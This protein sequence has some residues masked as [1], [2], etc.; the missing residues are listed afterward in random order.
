[1]CRLVTTLLALIVI[2]TSATFCGGPNSFAAAAVCPGDYSDRVA[3]AASEDGSWASTADR[4]RHYDET[5]LD[6]VL[7]AMEKALEFMR[8]EAQNLNLDAIIGTRIVE[9]QLDVLLERL[10]RATNDSELP[11]STATMQRIDVIRR[12]AGHVSDMATPY[13]REY[14]ADYF[15]RIGAIIG[16]HF[17]R[18]DYKSRDL[19]MA[20]ATERRI[21]GEAMHEFDSDNCLTELFGTTGRTDVKC[22]VSRACWELMT[23]PGYQHYSLT[24]QCFYFEIGQSYGCFGSTVLRRL[25]D[26]LNAEF[27]AAIYAESL[28]IAADA[29]PDDKHD[30]FMEQAA[31]CGM[32]GYRQFFRP[33]WLAAILS[34]Q[35]QSR[36]CYGLDRPPTAV[37][38]FK[39]EE[40]LLEDGCLCHRTAVAIGALVQ[41]IRYIIEAAADAARCHS[42]G[43]TARQLH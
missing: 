43:A 27:C 28:Q 38:R 29:F 32:L 2:S 22:H 11:V 35:R 4:R 15:A 1:M 3:A 19:D 41:Y 8:S 17:W 40:R 31:L 12:A 13:I 30:L 7:T 9:G 37:S 33:D 42:G 36:G 21:S 16:R 25:T 18:L 5:A 34:W 10:R 24:H 20:A 23:A 39:R 14:Q 26:R 6:V